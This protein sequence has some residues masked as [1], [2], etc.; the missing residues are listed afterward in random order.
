MEVHDWIPSNILDENIKYL[1]R[2]QHHSED[3]QESKDDPRPQT[4]IV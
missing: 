2:W 1:L 3:D 4:L